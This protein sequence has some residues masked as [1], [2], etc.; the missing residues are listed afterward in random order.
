MQSRGGSCD[1]ALIACEHGLV[2]GRVAVVRRALRG[3]VRRQRWLAEI[4]DRLVE[5]RPVERK[6]QRDLALVALGC[7]LGIEMA[8]QAYLALVAETDSVARQQLLCR[9]D[10]RLP[11]RAVEPRDQGRLALRLGG[12]A[13]PAPA[14]VPRYRPGAADHEPVAGTEPWRQ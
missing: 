1:R 8:E 11:A 12:A 4:G 10:Q 2:V 9:L 6:R 7:D 3:D 13:E 5:R 14:H